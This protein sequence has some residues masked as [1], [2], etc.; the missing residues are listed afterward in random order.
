MNVNKWYN[1]NAMGYLDP[2]TAIAASAG[3][4]LVG[5]MLQGDASKSA[6]NTAANAQRDA[7]NIAAKSAEFKPYNLTSGFGTSTMTPTGGSYTLDPTL[8]AYRNQMY[9][10]AN[11]SLPTTFDPTQT[12]QRYYQQQQDILAP[13]RERAFAA[14]QNS[15]FNQGTAGLAVG[16]TGARPY[17]GGAGLGASNPTLEAYF[18]SLNQQDL[19]LQQNA[20]Q[21]GNQQLDQQIARSTGLFG[22]GTGIEKLGYGVMSDSA[23]IGNRNTANAMQAAQNTYNANVGA[24]NMMAQANSIS[25]FATATQSLGKLDWSKVFGTN[26]SGVTGPY[27]PDSVYNAQDAVAARYNAE[28]GF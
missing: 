6:A 14:L 16:A 23:N 13:E 3:L 19:Q 10:G 15:I 11:Q 25:P 8:A 28:Q 4:N 12:A 7:A 18:N 17:S 1:R 21:Y 26:T 2:G 5:G 24:A 20:Q 9:A 22:Q 27:I